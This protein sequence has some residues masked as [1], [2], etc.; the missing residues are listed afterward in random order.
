MSTQPLPFLTVEEYLAI[1]REA[2]FRSE[3]LN[4]EVFAMARGTYNHALVATN[5]SRI[6]GDQ[7]RGT[8]CNVT[9]SDVRLFCKP[10]NMMT[11]PDLIVSCK[12]RQFHD[13]HRDTLTDATVIIEVLS[14]STRNYDRGEKFRFYRGLPSFTE[15]L[16]LEQDSYRAEQYVKQPDRSWV[17]REFEGPETVIELGSIDCRFPLGPLYD[18]VEFPA[19]VNPAV[20]P[21]D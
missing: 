19:P 11:Y 6:I 15:Y 1:E 21:T 4:G 12:P 14:P 2:D 16:L 17:F 8:H 18:G 7:L 13:A 9:G 3:Y 10:A 20:S 5:V